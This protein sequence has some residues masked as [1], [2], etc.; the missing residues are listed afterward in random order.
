MQKGPVTFNAYAYI[1]YKLAV[2]KLFE[3][4]NYE[5]FVI[6]GRTGGGG[7]Y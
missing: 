2:F 6:G 1:Q 5:L 7:G 3:L 4:N